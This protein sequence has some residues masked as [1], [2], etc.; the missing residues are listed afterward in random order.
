MGVN[1]PEQRQAKQMPED[2]W[3]SSLER[4]YLESERGILSRAITSLRTF[5]LRVTRRRNFPRLTLNFTDPLLTKLSLRDQ[6]VEVAPCDIS[7][8]G[9]GLDVPHWSLGDLKI[10]HLLSL[11]VSFDGQKWHD[12]TGEIR[13]VRSGKQARGSVGIQFKNPSPAILQAIVQYQKN[14]PGKF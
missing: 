10:G 1:V 13:Y 12:I 3:E 14:R 11:R 4:D 2:L 8:G 5:F 7:Q 9:M 6:E